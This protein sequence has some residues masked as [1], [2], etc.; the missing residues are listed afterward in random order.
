MVYHFAMSFPS[1]RAILLCA[2]YGALSVVF[3]AP[4]FEQPAGLGVNDWDQHLFYYGAVLKNVVEYGQAPF[5][6]P[7]YCGGNVLWQNP[8]V[9]LLSPV[10]PLSVIL[11]LQLAT[12]VSILLHYWVGFLGMHLLLTRVVGLSFLPA[13]I[14]LAT[15]VTAAGAPAIHVAVGHSVFLP[16][17]YLPAQLYFLFRAYQTG[18]I[19][20]ALIAAALLALMVFNGGVHILPMAFAS[21]GCFAVLVTVMT[22][23]WRPMV[24][25]VVFVVAGL[26]YAAPK[27]LPV[28]LFV[29][30]ERFWDTR[31]PTEHPDRMTLDMVA[32]AYLNPNQDLRTKLDHQR[33]GW[34]EYGNY[35]GPASAVLLMAGFLVAVWGRRAPDAWFGRALALTAGFLFLLSLG[36]FSAWSPASLLKHVPLF[37]SFRIPSRYTIPCL[38]FGA[39]ALAWVMRGFSLQ[40]RSRAVQAIAGA[41][42]LVIA[43]HLVMVN[44]AQFV[45]VFRV[46]PFDTAFRWL[47][48]PRQGITTDAVSSAYTHD[49]PMLRALVSDRFFYYCYESLQL[50]RASNPEQPLLFTEGGGATTELGFTPNRVDFALFGGAQPARLYLNYNW[51]PGWTSTAGDID[52]PPDRIASVALGPGQTGRFSFSFVP[53]GLWLGTAIML[54]ALVLS[55]VLWRRLLLFG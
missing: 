39:M 2:L 43:A 19:K 33:H 41:A 47:D 48:G 14:Y 44:R 12:K 50:V 15:L 32:H 21:I 25:T 54:A 26:A 11:P 7:W 37:S 5:W 35:I 13:V 9:A 40:T 52:H 8:Q 20:D 27:L 29:A 28:S 3:C 38:L 53:P 36:E 4:L 23:R 34:H 30:G 16:G 45:G 10:Y 51:G 17:F 24:M 46:V 6:N 42:C 55:A 1:R 49:S 18:A 22:R 31:N